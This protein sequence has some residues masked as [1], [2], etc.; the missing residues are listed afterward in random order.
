[1]RA[2]DT[3]PALRPAAYLCSPPQNPTAER[4][5]E[6]LTSFATRLG[7]PA[8]VFYLDH[9][10][11]SSWVHHARPRFE[12]LVLAM[13][14]GTHRILLIPG[15]W[16]F[17]GDD[18]RVRLSVRVLTAAGCTRILMPPRHATPVGRDQ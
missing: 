4:D 3:S 1:M 18:D 17:S 7:L 5:R 2:P 11:P 14:D 10:H 8:P 12:E 6:A 16:V 15:T 13:I 9:A